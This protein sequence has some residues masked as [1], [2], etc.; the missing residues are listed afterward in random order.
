M[1]HREKFAGNMATVRACDWPNCTWRGPIHSDVG[2]KGWTTVKRFDGIEL[3]LCS[4]HTSL[5]NN[6]EFRR[7]SDESEAVEF[8]RK[9]AL[10]W[11]H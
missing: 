8:T 5:L 11:H 9:H 3:D 6:P 7:G 4:A 2:T 1:I 10:G